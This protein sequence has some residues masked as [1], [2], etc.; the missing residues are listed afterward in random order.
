MVN[1]IDNEE[2]IGSTTST[3]VKRKY[4]HKV[5]STRTPNTLVYKHFNK[6]GW[7]NVEIILIES[8]PCEN[9]DELLR[10]ERFWFDELK[11]SLNK[12]R[13]YVSDEEKKEYITGN[14]EKLAKKAVVYYQNNKEKIAERYQ[15]NKEKIAGYYQNNKEK[16][17]EHYQNNKE[18]IAEHY[19]K[20]KVKIAERYQNNKEDKVNCPCGSCINQSGYLIHLKSK[21]HLKYIILNNEERL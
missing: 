14:K 16:I 19:Q 13:P 10:R 4:Q 15:N 17:A 8:C 5:F 6:I 21:K 18:N 11:P 12:N 2:Y 9:R 20:N 7:E 3:L 1:N